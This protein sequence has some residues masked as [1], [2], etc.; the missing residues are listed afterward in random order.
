MIIIALHLCL[1]VL[2]QFLALRCQYLPALVPSLQE[3]LPEVRALVPYL[4]LLVQQL[5]ELV[6]AATN[7]QLPSPFAPSE[8]SDKSSQ[9][10]NRR[11]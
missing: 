7:A 5:R 1:L 10:E 3:L 8:Y 4:Q 6:Q 11:I 9:R 2:L